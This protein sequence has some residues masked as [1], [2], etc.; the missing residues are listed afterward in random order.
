VV[1]GRKQVSEAER[2]PRKAPQPVRFRESLH[3]SLTQRLRKMILEHELKPGE[4]I[5]ELELCQ[6]LGISRTPMREALK[7][8]AAE[9]LVVLHPYRGATVTEIDPTILLELFEI[10]AILES[11]AGI[12]ACERASQEDIEAFG[13]KH[14]KMIQHFEGNRR[15]AYFAVNQELHC[16][17]VAMCGNA[18]LAAMHGNVMEQIERA[19]FL[20]L[21]AAHRWEHSIEQ[22]EGI[23]DALRKRDPNLIAARIRTHVLDTG[24][25]VVSAVADALAPTNPADIDA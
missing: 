13:A 19:R 7:V 1:A 14:A 9:K 5:Q 24:T 15:K 4:W 21:D 18:S 20:A 2:G 10:Q 23:L 17:I 25:T 3:D 22:H 8:L 11:Q 6:T 12:L 16:A